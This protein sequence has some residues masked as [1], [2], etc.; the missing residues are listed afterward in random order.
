MG[1]LLCWR[2]ED[3]ATS[4]CS[5]SLYCTKER[6]FVNQRLRNVGIIIWNIWLYKISYY[7]HRKFSNSF[8]FLFYIFEIKISIG[9]R[10]IPTFF[11]KWYF[12]LVFRRTALREDDIV[13]KSIQTIFLISIYWYFFLVLSDYHF[14][15]Y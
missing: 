15:L 14:D 5:F 11:F 9:F 1:I 2:F 7:L 6:T 8:F 3:S 4:L 12:Q 13:N 10:P